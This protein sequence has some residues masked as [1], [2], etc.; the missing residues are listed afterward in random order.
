MNR[1]KEYLSNIIHPFL[2]IGV[3]LI[4]GAFVIMAVGEQPMEI[5]RVMFKG[6]FG[7]LYYL[8]ATLTRA[9]PIIITGLGAAIAWNSNYMG[10]GGEGQ[11]IW[12]GFI[13]TIITLYMGGPV[14]VVLPVAILCA[15][16]FGGLYSIFSAYLLEKLNMSL[17]ITTLMLNYVAQYVTFHYVSNV[18]L[19]TSGMARSVQT[20]QIDEGFFFMQLFDGYSLHIGFIIAVVLVFATWFFM[21]RTTVGYEFKMN[22]YNEN[23]CKYGGIKSRKTMYLVLFISGA[24]C[25]F[26]GVVEIYGVQHRF[27]QGMYVTTSFA[28]MGLVAALISGYNP[29]GVLFTSIILAAISTGGTAVDRST[30]IPLEI[31]SIIQGCITLFISARLV[32]QFRMKQKKKVVDPG[33][34]KEGVTD[35]V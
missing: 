19:D 15:I 27:L 3:S 6:A 32:I 8:S 35:G 2:A 16:L 25:A 34:E 14:I 29:I 21:N 13:A 30:D 28:W 24:L 9:T 5:Y 22:G 4:M 18:F 20:V 10:I 26:G 33:L 7:S 1:I 12:G 23:F 11:M 31:A 17:A